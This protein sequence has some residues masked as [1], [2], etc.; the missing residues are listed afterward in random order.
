MADVIS[1]SRKPANTGMLANVSA[2]RRGAEN[3]LVLNLKEIREELMAGTTGL[4]PATSDVTG[5]RSNQLNYVPAVP[6]RR[7]SE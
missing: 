5:R 1:A 6:D 2:A 7:P 4:E 3:P